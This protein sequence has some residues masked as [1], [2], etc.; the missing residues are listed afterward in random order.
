LHEA[1]AQPDGHP[2][3]LVLTFP[4]R[5]IQG[6]PPISYGVDFHKRRCESR[7]SARALVFR[8]QHDLPTSIEENASVDAI[9]LDFEFQM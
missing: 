7:D 3:F 1:V 8:I 2:L 9:A 6:L 5:D 4:V